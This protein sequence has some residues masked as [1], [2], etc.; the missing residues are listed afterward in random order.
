MC[1]NTPAWRFSSWII[2]V[3]WGCVVPE[4]CSGHRR[5]AATSA[6]PVSCPLALDGGSWV[7]ASRWGSFSPLRSRR[8]D[9]ERER[10]PAPEGTPHTHE[11]SRWLRTVAERWNRIRQKRLG[12]TLPYVDMQDFIYSFT[13]LKCRKCFA[14]LDNISLHVDY[15]WGCGHSCQLGLNFGFIFL[16]SCCYPAFRATFLT[17]PC[18]CWVNLTS[19][20]I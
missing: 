8:E 19:K 17:T 20:V 3:T 12:L 5:A 14:F 6:W 13:L 16:K 11:E 2:T 4:V 1:P 7:A 18:S 10:Q 9:P 15:V